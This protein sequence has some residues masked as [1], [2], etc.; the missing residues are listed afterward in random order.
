MI[1]LT[2]LSADHFLVLFIYPYHCHLL[3]LLLLEFST[4]TFSRHSNMALERKK[5]KLN[6]WFSKFSRLS[7]LCR[8][9]SVSDWGQQSSQIYSVTPPHFTRLFTLTTYMFVCSVWFYSLAFLMFSVAQQFPLCLTSLKTLPGRY[10]LLS[11]RCSWF[12]YLFR[13]PQ[14]H[15]SNICILILQEFMF[16]RNASGVS[17]SF[18]FRFLAA[19]R[20]VGGFISLLHRKAVQCFHVSDICQL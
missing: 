5:K 12:I 19:R 2:R 18:R 6:E 8:T 13:F 11:T 3:A 10:C 16:A 15:F 20:P 1:I 14:A 7:P 4:D 17:S 9:L